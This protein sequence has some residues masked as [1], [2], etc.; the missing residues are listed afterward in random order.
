MQTKKPTVPFGRWVIGSSNSDWNLSRTTHLHYAALT[1]AKT[2]CEV[3][4]TGQSNLLG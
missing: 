4:E 1:A 2:H 3:E